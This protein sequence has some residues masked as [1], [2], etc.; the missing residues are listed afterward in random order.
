MIEYYNFPHTNVSTIISGGSK[1]SAPNSMSEIDL[2]GQ[3]AFRAG[4]PM[5]FSKNRKL[6]IIAA[7]GNGDP[8]SVDCVA[9][10]P[11]Y[12]RNGVGLLVRSTLD[13]KS[14]GF[15]LT[16][17]EPESELLIKHARK[18]STTILHE[19][20]LTIGRG[21]TPALSSRQSTSRNHIRIDYDLGQEREWMTVADLGSTNGTTLYLEELE[22]DMDYAG[23]RGLYNL[24]AIL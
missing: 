10:A 4:R 11:V 12:I 13:M 5:K 21:A 20:E 8:N 7:L 1:P 2:Q 18:Q 16:A 22:A 6:P 23:E 14:G 24:N 3:Q 15:L 19:G 9:I 17:E